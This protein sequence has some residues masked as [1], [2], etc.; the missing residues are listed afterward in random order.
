VTDPIESLM[1]S[2]ITVQRCYAQA[3]LVD[4]VALTAYQDSNDVL[5]AAQ[6]LKAA[7]HT[8]VTPLL[9]KIR[10]EAG[11]AVDPVATYRASGYRADMAATRPASGPSSGIV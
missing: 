7:F 8:D 4:R 9:Q 11:G 2:A 5:M 1:T 10:L 6:T 3:L